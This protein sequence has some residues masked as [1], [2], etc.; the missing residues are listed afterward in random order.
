MPSL[1]KKLNK[2]NTCRD[3]CP[4]AINAV[5]QKY[6]AKF[7]GMLPAKAKDGSWLLDPLAVF[8]QEKPPVEGYSNYMGLLV[9]NGE[10]YITSGASAVEGVIIGV[11]ADNGEIIYSNCRWDMRHST[12][13]SVWIDGGR[14]YTRTSGGKIVEMVIVDGE[15]YELLNIVDASPALK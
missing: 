15:F 1:L 14:D 10:T 9:R 8:W 4:F 7:V 2:V 13:G 11:V 6:N 12:D 3:D 5:E